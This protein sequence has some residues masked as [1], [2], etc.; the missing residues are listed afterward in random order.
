MKKLLSLSL[1]L[2]TIVSCSENDT[3]SDP[4]IGKWNLITSFEGSVDVTN[5]C[6]KQSYITFSENFSLKGEV[7]IE[8]NNECT[9][10]DGP[11]SGT[12]SKQNTNNYSLSIDNSNSPIEI[13]IT[14]NN[15]IQV[16]ED[17]GSIVTTYKKQ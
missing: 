14:N 11:Y 15:L 9:S 16:I 17:S 10:D 13:S 12:W 6:L 7:I 4:I 3:T 5:D 8:M 2:L 1:I